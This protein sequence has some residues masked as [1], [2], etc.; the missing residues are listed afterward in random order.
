M[1]FATLLR[2][3]V[4][5]H[6]RHTF[7]NKQVAV[8]V[9]FAQHQQTNPTK[10]G[11]V[12]NL[13]T[14]TSSNIKKPHVYILF[15]SIS[16]RRTLLPI[17]SQPHQSFLILFLIT[18]DARVLFVAENVAAV[19]TSRHRWHQTVSWSPLAAP[20][21]RLCRA[22]YSLNV[23]GTKSCVCICICVCFVGIVAFEKKNNGTFCET[24]EGVK[25]PVVALW[26]EQP[27]EEHYGK[28]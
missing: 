8:V 24:N 19:A 7:T 26:K 22:I 6:L 9:I 23:I 12:N 1:W 17:L 10:V 28:W 13:S 27:E 21:E 25:F 15:Q 11:V 2:S 3:T 14:T 16:L 5:T 18:L 4:I 20:E